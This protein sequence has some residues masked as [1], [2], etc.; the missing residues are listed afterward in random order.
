MEAVK[1]GTVTAGMLMG[2]TLTEAFG[3]STAL[4]ANAGTYVVATGAALAL[5]TRRARADG[6]GEGH[7]GMAEGL[8]LL[9]RDRLLRIMIGVLA[10]SVLFAGVDNVANV[11]FAREVLD[12][13]GAGYGALSAAW[14]MGMV[15]GAVVAGRRI[16]PRLAPAA[17]LGAVGLMGAGIALTAATAAF[18]PA[19]AFLLLGG[20]GNAVDNI[21]IRIVLQDRVEERM[22]GRAYGGFQGFMTI[23]D[24]V[25]LASG[26]VLVELIGPRATLLLAG[27]G[28]VVAGVLGL[29]ALRLARGRR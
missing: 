2:G 19:L 17:M 15:V 3:A 29:P 18:V 22:R 13:G 11:F 25:A 1:Y 23:A 16:G 7:G 20:I 26:G 10:G 12:V 4:L 27:L 6:D 21:G 24:F 8:R 9:W 14:G 5:R 28:C